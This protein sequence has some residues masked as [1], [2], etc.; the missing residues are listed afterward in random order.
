MCSYLLCKAREKSSRTGF[1][2]IFAPPRNI[3]IVF[4]KYETHG[5]RKVGIRSLW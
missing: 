5:N 2:K 4:L 3:N 1:Q